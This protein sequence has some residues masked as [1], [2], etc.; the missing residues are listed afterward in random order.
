[1]DLLYHLVTTVYYDSLDANLDCFPETFGQD[2]FV[3]CTAEKGEMGKVANQFYKPG[4][5][6]Y[7]YLYIDK[8]RVRAPVRCEDEENKYPHI[9]GPLNRDAVVAVRPAR[10]DQAGDSLVPDELNIG[11]ER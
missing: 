8:A 2:G 11:R 5:G 7:L 4:A 6:P 1:M 9:F 10:R 3:H